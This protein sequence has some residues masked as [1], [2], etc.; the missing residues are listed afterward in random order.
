M[1]DMD[2][3]FRGLDIPKIHAVL[4]SL[5]EEQERAKIPYTI[6]RAEEDKTA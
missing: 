6:E 1:K 3:D 2:A 5:L 4:I